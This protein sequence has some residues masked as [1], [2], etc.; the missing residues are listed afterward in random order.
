MN[1]PSYR[2]FFATYPIYQKY[3]TCSEFHSI[4][5]TITSK[6]GLYRM[7]EAVEEGRPAI[8][9]VFSL[10]EKEAG[11]ELALGDHFTRQAIGMLIRFVLTN[12]GYEPTIQKNIQKDKGSK[13]FVSGMHYKRI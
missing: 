11:E 7:K 10:V 1:T 8:E 13:F 4:Y 12:R 6:D 5:Q 3:E 2:S 9:G